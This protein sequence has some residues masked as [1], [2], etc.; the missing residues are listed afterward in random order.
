MG[1]F[2]LFGLIHGSNKRKVKKENTKPNSQKAQGSSTSTVVD[3]G[4][5]SA[6]CVS[7]PESSIEITAARIVSCGANYPYQALKGGSLVVPVGNFWRKNNAVRTVQCRAMEIVTAQSTHRVAC[8]PKIH[9]GRQRTQTGS[10][11]TFTL[12]YSG[13]AGMCLQHTVFVTKK[14]AP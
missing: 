12:F 4:A 10:E 7:P 1:C 6:V 13:Q 8:I 9:L 2:F 14:L 5:H 3:V 11:C